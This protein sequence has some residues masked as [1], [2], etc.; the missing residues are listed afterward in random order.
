MIE[1]RTVPT[2]S[3]LPHIVY[4]NVAG[5]IVWLAKAFGFTEHFRYGDP[6]APSGAQLYL[7]NS[8]I[9]VRSARGGAKSP[10]Q[11]GYGTQS[12]SIFVEDVDGHFQR[13]KAA[14]AN[15]VEEPHETEYGEYQFAATDLDGHHW[16][17]AR[18]A[19]DMSP[20]DW[21]AVISSVPPHRLA[22]LPKPRFCYLQI[23]A[24]DVHQSA[25]FYEKVFGWNIRRRESGHPS[26]DDATG[27]L[28]GA[29]FTDLKIA[30]EP[31]LLLS[32]WV[33]G[34]DAVLAKIAESGGEIIEP[35]HHDAPDSSC[36]IA[37]FRDPAGNVLRLYQ[38]APR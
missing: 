21:G 18:H 7:A 9:M 27:N 15:I 32:I 3:P 20:A 5:A 36:W 2:N 8:W 31:G 38:E 34:I 6:A 17:F 1:N 16:V 29:W 4:Q 13:A 23:P 12:V 22:S 35:V 30:R 33:D 10:A 37:T 11:L 19:R 25:A 28:S 26:F 24:I 14:G